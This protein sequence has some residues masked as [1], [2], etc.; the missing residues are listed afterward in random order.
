MLW[1]YPKKLFIL[2]ILYYSQLRYCLIALAL[3]ASERTLQHGLTASVE[4][5]KLLYDR[6]L[7]SL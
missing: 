1:Q 2:Y 3:A 7:Y 4:L 5:H 6:F